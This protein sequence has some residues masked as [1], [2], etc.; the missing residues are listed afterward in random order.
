[1]ALR[2]IMILVVLLVALPVSV[3][4]ADPSLPSSNGIYQTDETELATWRAPEFGLTFQYPANWQSFSDPSFEFILIASQSEDGTVTEF[5]GMQSR[6]LAEDETMR[7]Y[8]DQFQST[9][10]GETEATEFAGQ[11]A[12]SLPIPPDASGS[13]VLL[14]GFM[15]DESRFALLIFS[16]TAENW[17]AFS[18]Q[19]DGI[20]SSAEVT[21]LSLDVAAL[22]AQMLANFEEEKILRL[23][24]REAGV[25]LVEVL[26]FSCPHCA[27]YES[28][29]ERVIQDYVNPEQVLLEFRIAT[30]VRGELSEVAAEAQYCAASLG[31]GWRA[32]Q[33]LFEI[34]RSQGAEGFTV[35][36][37]TETL[38]AL[39]GVDGQAF[40]ECLSERRYRELWERDMDYIGDVGVGGT[41]SIL[42]GTATEPPALLTDA[43]GEPRSG[44]IRLNEV[45]DYLDSL[46]ADSDS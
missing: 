46:L 35:G 20:V 25:T 4:A 41:P 32:H 6:V 29:I 18:G 38:S 8:F 43:N 2:N 34:Q 13:Q 28:D 16:G 14:I 37:V 40:S 15:A 42:F 44:G 9:Y 17:E 27:D 39:E 36:N 7:V 26:D 30:F 33:A 3:Q 31:F 10:G 24:N 12:L 22:D 23:G 11:E 45:Y 19:I 1:M 21:P 5:M